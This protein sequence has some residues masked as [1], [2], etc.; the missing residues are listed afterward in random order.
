MEEEP[1]D[2]AA[3]MLMHQRH[4]QINRENKLQEAQKQAKEQSEPTNDNQQAQM[5]YNPVTGQ[6]MTADA[7]QKLQD[8]IKRQNERE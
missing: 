2:L 8:F 1:Q 3:T 4:Q 7:Y 6:E 5:Y